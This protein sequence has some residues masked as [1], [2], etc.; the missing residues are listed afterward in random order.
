MLI[1]STRHPHPNKHQYPNHYAHM[2][3]LSSILLPRATSPTLPKCTIMLY[4]S[5]YLCQ[6]PILKSHHRSIPH[7]Y[8][9][10]ITQNLR[11]RKCRKTVYTHLLIKGSMQYGRQYLQ[12]PLNILLPIRV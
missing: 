2:P 3:T 1:K 10:S 5:V 12:S 7:W 9:H 8:A 11:G 6:E 4:Q